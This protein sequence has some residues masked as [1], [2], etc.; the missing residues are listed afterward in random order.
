MPTYKNDPTQI[1]TEI[2][3]IQKGFIE[4]PSQSSHK[5]NPKVQTALAIPKTTNPVMLFL[6]N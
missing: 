2:T 3:K 5:P 4:N 6:L 1:I